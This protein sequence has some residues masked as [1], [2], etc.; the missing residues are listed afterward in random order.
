MSIG[1]YA[2][3]FKDTDKLY[4]GR[5]VSLDTRLH[6]HLYS[7][8]HGIASKKLQDAYNIYGEPNIQILEVCNIDSIYSKERFYI[9]EFNSIEEGF[10]TSSGGEAGNTSFGEDNSRALG[11]TEQYIDALELLVTTPLT[12]SDIAEKVGLTESSVQH[13]CALETH[14]WLADAEPTLYSRLVTQKGIHRNK[15]LMNAKRKFNRLVSPEGVEY[16]LTQVLLKTFC[17]EHGLTESHISAV[18]NGRD[19]QHKGWHT[20]KYTITPRPKPIQVI[21]PSKEVYSVQYGDY[22][23]FARKHGLDPGAF[24]KVI[25]G[26]ANHHHGWRLYSDTTN[27]YAKKLGLDPKPQ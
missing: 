12:V 15:I 23:S 11:T 19:I 27:D 13:L 20:G 2:L 17:T 3:I 4:I 8:R 26:T 7:M 18:L 10:N 5:S 16:D 22:S 6:S 14:K 1:I 21:S 9:A 24:R 25:A